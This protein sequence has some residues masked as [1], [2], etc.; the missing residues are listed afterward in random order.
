LLYAGGKATR[1]NPASN[2]RPYKHGTAAIC[3]VLGIVVLVWLFLL[4]RRPL[5]SRFAS[6]SAV[7]VL[8]VILLCGGVIL[9]ILIFFFATCFS[10]QTA[11]ER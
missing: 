10:I 11:L 8:G 7:Q 6:D 4:F 5:A 9:A 3:A 2:V 1:D